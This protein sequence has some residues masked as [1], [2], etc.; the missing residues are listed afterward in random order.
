MSYAKALA[1]CDGFAKAV[2]SMVRVGEKDNCGSASISFMP[3]LQ[4]RAK[5]SRSH[6]EF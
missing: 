5:L 2:A 6:G 1:L 4:A 3:K